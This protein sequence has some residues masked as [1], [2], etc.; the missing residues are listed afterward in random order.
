MQINLKWPREKKLQY[1]R[2]SKGRKK[3]DKA[4]VVKS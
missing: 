2:E 3:N 1:V 4:E